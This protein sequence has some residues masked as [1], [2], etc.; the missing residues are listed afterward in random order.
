MRP[1][2]RSPSSSASIGSSDWTELQP[3]MKASVTPK[4]SSR[5][6]TSDWSVAGMSSTSAVWAMS[7]KSMI[8]L[9]APAS[10]SSRLSSVRSLWMTCERSA[11]KAGAI[12]SAKRAMTRS[13][14]VRRRPSFTSA[15]CSKRSGSRCW[16]QAITRPAAGWKKARSA[17]ATRAATTPISRTCSADTSFGVAL[18]PGRRGRSRTRCSASRTETAPM[19]APPRVGR[20]TGTGSPGSTAA[21]CSTAATSISTTPRASAPFETF[22]TQLRPSVPT[23]SKFW[24]RSLT[25]AR[26]DPSTPNSLRAIRAASAS[27]SC[28][29]SAFRTSGWVIGGW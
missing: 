13:S 14:S 10:S 27:L 25:S 6:R 7:P 20:A 2:S 22:S 5:S 24:S 1:A 12:R 29:G 3:T 8:P 16:S 21:M 18:R 15:A 11:G 26:A 23:I 4:R 28:G 19:L 9:T 17:C